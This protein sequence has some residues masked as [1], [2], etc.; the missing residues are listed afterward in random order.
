MA[1]P[2]ETH[3]CGVLLRTR[4]DSVAVGM[5]VRVL[6]VVP[7]GVP[8]AAT[9]RARTLC[10]VSVDLD[11][12]LVITG[13]RSPAHRRAVLRPAR[14]NDDRCNDASRSGHS[15]HRKRPTRLSGLRHDV[16]PPS[17]GCRGRDMSPFPMY[18]KITL[19]N[20]VITTG[21]GLE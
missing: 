19:R 13:S 20:N 3:T 18:L 8:G 11:F 6:S 12:R 10:S 7:G 4:S 9:R 5:R 17:S 15:R 2:F 14:G 16:E 21:T 1:S